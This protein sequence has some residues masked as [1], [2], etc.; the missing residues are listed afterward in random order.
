M[1]RQV[2]V[3]RWDDPALTAP[4]VESPVKLEPPKGLQTVDQGK[5]NSPEPS[6]VE[7]T[8]KTENMKR[9][10]W[11]ESWDG[12]KAATQDE[13][14]VK[15]DKP[16]RQKWVDRWDEPK[17]VPVEDPVRKD[18][19]ERQR[20]ADGL[21]AINQKDEQE[22]PKRRVWVDRWDIRESGAQTD[23]IVARI[24]GDLPGH[25]TESPRSNEVQPRVKAPE[26]NAQL[27]KQTT[28]SPF[29]KGPIDEEGGTTFKPPEASSYNHVS[30]G[31]PKRTGTQSSIHLDQAPDPKTYRTRAQQDNDQSQKSLPKNDG[32]SPKEG[33]PKLRG[34]QHSRWAQAA[35]AEASPNGY[36]TPTKVNTQP[37][38]PTTITTPFKYIGRTPPQ[39]TSS[40]KAS[41]S[42]STRGASGTAPTLDVSIPLALASGLADE[43]NRQMKAA[44]QDI[45]K[46]AK[47]TLPL[48]NVKQEPIGTNKTDSNVNTTA[49]PLHESRQRAHLPEHLTKDGKPAAARSSPRVPSVLIPRDPNTPYTKV[50]SQSG[51]KPG[52]SGSASKASDSQAAEAVIATQFVS[53]DPRG[54]FPVELDME[55]DWN[56]T[57]RPKPM[58]QWDTT[59]LHSDDVFVLTH[60]TRRF[61]EWWAAGIPDVKANFLEQCIQRHQD[62]DVDAVTGL[63]MKPIEYEETHR[64]KLL[65]LLELSNDD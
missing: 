57:R 54:E 19:T 10:K 44:T 12:P 30:T 20:W 37:R 8:T 48:P 55:Q 29:S 64:R 14:P 58:K 43:Q 4:K 15:L 52:W 60:A 13:N 21:D 34:L 49:A 23:N 24:R 35:V 47:A 7:I 9:Q 59:S 50:G 22:K 2:W 28:P 25:S 51:D 11:V 31:I 65:M 16:K 42:V 33:T 18:E 38:Q 32:S 61:L 53:R 39:Y 36:H 3:D 45:P 17:K 6:K 1:K 46:E 26:Q 40:M 41:Q 5:N 27:G 56:E 62:C 63:L